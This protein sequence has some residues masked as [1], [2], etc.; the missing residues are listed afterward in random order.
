[1]IDAA[2][3]CGHA[4]Q[5]DVSSWEEDAFVWLTGGRNVNF[6]YRPMVLVDGADGDLEFN[7]TGHDFV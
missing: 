7:Q 6:G 2:P 1:M 3:S 4:Q 5:D